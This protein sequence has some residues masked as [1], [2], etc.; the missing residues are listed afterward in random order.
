[1]AAK[2]KTVSRAVGKAKPKP[3]PSK[4]SFYVGPSK[5]K[6]GKA[7]KKHIDELAKKNKLGK[8]IR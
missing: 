3:K 2:I 7:T 5:E 4:P 6:L 1:M 8:G